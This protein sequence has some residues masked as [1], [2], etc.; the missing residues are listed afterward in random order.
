MHIYLSLSFLVASWQE[1]T[2]YTSLGNID[3][4]VNYVGNSTMCDNGIST[5]WYRFV[6]NAGTQISTSCIPRNDTSILKC[7][8]HGVS[9][10]NGAHPSVSKRNVTRTVC[11]SWS[12]NCCWHSKDI[13]VINCGS[14]YIYKLVSTGSCYHRYCG[15]DV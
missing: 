12:G 8:T 5:G 11:F 3:R 13:Q 6:G 7:S 15:I 10:L 1:C 2:S 9:W 14:F 4:N